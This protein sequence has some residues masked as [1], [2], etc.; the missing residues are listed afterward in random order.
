M[1]MN[2]HVVSR[3]VYIFV[4]IFIINYRNILVLGYL[5]HTLVWCDLILYLIFLLFS[6][7][8]VINFDL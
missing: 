3:V 8:K 6:L 4:C 2:T 5:L 1:Y 7:E